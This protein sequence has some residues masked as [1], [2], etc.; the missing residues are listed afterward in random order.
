MLIF[1]P[2]QDLHM[3]DTDA[4]NSRGPPP[5]VAQLQMQ[6]QVGSSRPADEVVI[7]CCN[8]VFFVGEE[9]MEKTGVNTFC[10]FDASL[11]L[12]EGEK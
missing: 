10:R 2:L 8:W 4:G 12:L 1:S 6:N 11:N 3:E 7:W 9:L 5:M